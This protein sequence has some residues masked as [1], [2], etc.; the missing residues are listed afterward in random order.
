MNVAIDSTWIYQFN[1]A[2]AALATPAGM[3]AI[4]IGVILLFLSLAFRNARMFVMSLMLW[5]ASLGYY[6]A[7][8]ILVAPFEQIRTYGR[9]ITTAL[10]MI[11]LIPALAAQKGWRRRALSGAALAFFI[12]EAVFTF[13]EVL[14]GEASGGGFGRFALGSILYT[15]TFIVLAYGLPRWIQSPDDFQRAINAVG[16]TA[17]IFCGVT[18]LQTMVNRAV[19]VDGNGRLFG[20]TGN[21]QH[22]AVEL[23]LMLTPLCYLVAGKGQKVIMRVLFGCVAAVAGIFLLWTGSRTGVLMALVGL[24][25]MFRYRMGRLMLLASFAALFVMMFLSIYSTEDVVSEHLTSGEDTR[26]AIW[27][28]QFQGFLAH[29]ILGS[30]EGAFGYSEN[31]YLATGARYGL[32]GVVPL[33]VF[34]WFG[35][36]AIRRL[37]RAKRNLGDMRLAADMV[38]GNLLSLAVGAWFEAYL[39]G[40]LTMMVYMIYID[41]ALMNSLID[42][43]EVK[44]VQPHAFEPA[45]TEEQQAYAGYA[46]V[47][48]AF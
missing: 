18:F 9:G 33:L 13:R 30:D 43:A 28:G 5:T 20:T 17:A 39:L 26:S 16:I 10:L 2:L 29:P 44:S 36:R 46:P 7:G 22:C 24:V 42:I 4:A 14:A 34:M 41:F 37:S 32:V 3:I 1:N 12:F 21:P 8:R 47:A 38:L 45:M 25:V 35:F 11:L 40:V 15:L 23:A 19:I 27:E 31:S 6:S 48:E